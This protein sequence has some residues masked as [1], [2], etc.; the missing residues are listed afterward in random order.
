MFLVCTKVYLTVDTIITILS[1]VLDQDRCNATNARRCLPCALG[2]GEGEIS[3]PCL[4]FEPSE[5]KTVVRANVK[6]STL[7]YQGQA[8]RGQILTRALLGLVRPLPSAGGGGGGRSGPPSISETNRRGGKFKRQWKGLDEIFQIKF[9]NL[10]SRSPVTS[11][12]RSNKMF[13]MAPEY[14]GRGALCSAFI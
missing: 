9:K 7:G 14:G 11:Q 1:V 2:E 10:T 6:F 13:D 8:T 12:V 4:L 5:K 3:L